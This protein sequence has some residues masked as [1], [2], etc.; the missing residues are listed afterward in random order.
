[1]HLDMILG[2]LISIGASVS[3]TQS[4]LTSNSVDICRVCICKF[5]CDL[6]PVREA[7]KRA[8]VETQPNVHASLL[9]NALTQRVQY[10]PTLSSLDNR[11]DCRTCWRPILAY[12]RK[13]NRKD[14]NETN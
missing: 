9:F 13:W 3:Q 8:R 1:M 6:F 5:K 11:N 4:G 12:L 7:N 2:A 14:E 10:L